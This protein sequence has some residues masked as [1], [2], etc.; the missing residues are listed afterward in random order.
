[1]P[2]QDLIMVMT[3]NLYEGRHQPVRLLYLLFKACIHVVVFNY[4]MLYKLR[5]LSQISPPHCT[6]NSMRAVMNKIL[7]YNKAP[8]GA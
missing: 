3:N 6:L 1:M 4:W 5:H 7:L 8:K 2:D